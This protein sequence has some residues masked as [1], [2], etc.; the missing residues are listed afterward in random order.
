[1]AAKRVSRLGGLKR[2]EEEEEE[3]EKK[4]EEAGRDERCG[5]AWPGRSGSAGG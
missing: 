1:M 2:E 4:E 5:G 3:E